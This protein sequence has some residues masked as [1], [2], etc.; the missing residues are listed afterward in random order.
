MKNK[1]CEYCNKDIMRDSDL[2][3]YSYNKRKFCS[4]KCYWKSM[5]GIDKNGK[6]IN[7]K[8]CKYCNKIHYNKHF[9]SRLCERKYYDNKYK[10]KI[11][12]YCNKRI[13]KK[14]FVNN[15]S[16][17]NW[18]KRK[19]CSYRCYVKYDGGV[20][21]W[22]NKKVNPKLC[23][24]CNKKIFKR[25]SCTSKEWKNKK[26]CSIKCLNI[27]QGGRNSYNW[28]GGISFEPYDSN[29]NKVLKRYIAERDSWTCQICFKKRKKGHIHHI[30][31]N[32]QDSR[33]ETL[34]FLDIECH[35]KT[36]YN[37]DYWF[38]FF[39]YVLKRKPEEVFLCL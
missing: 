17:V 35:T 30:H 22:K 19:F 32:K 36:N 13:F 14:N 20:I 6:L 9:C 5:Y 25:K 31:Y 38:A 3:N 12:L 21:G 26:F 8:R 16:K 2:S 24:F 1:K 10:P 28:Q 23:I 29:F 15:V 34:I 11:C 18:L 7:K 39:C 37:R 4:L 27:W 33:P